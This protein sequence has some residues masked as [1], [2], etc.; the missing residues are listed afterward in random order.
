MQAVGAAYRRAGVRR[1]YL[2]HGTPLGPDAVGML[3]RLARAFP[4][5]GRAVR[6]VTARIIGALTGEVGSYTPQ[7]ARCLEAALR[8][9]GQPAIPVRLFHWS[10]ENHHIGR[11]DGAVRLI[12]ELAALDLAP[13]SRVMLWGHSH[14]GN[15]FAL[16]SHLLGDRRQ[17][18]EPF[19]KAAEIYYR[20]PLLRCVDIPLW[21]R[22][23]RLLLAADP[24]APDPVAL[25]VV[26]F[27]TPIRYGWN[28][29]GYSKLLHFVHHRPVPGMP[30]Y[31]AVFPPKLDDVL[32]A[33]DGDYVQQL[34]IAGTDLP[35]SLCAWRARLANRRLAQLLQEQLPPGGL[36][37]F[38]AGTIVP[39][40]GT[41]L[42]VDYGLPRCGIARHYAGH[43]VYTYRKWLLFHAEEIARRFYAADS[44]REWEGVA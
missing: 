10:G 38:R 39:D 23:R 19:F 6:R 36:E 4:A 28:A 41:T 26:T 21:N 34:G 2:A 5:A 11:G 7:Y 12:D 24:P 30:H 29:G 1:I 37:R 9:P 31:L 22:V 18:A 33:A 42:L 13:G 3:A 17:T 40:E 15:V 16:L 27:G 32:R 8:E 35:P 25:D 20:W 43:A 44:D 14:A